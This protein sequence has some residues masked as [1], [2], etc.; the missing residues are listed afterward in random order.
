MSKPKKWE[1][2]GINKKQKICKAGKI[3]LK[4]RLD[5]LT[6]TIDSY[7][8]EQS[9][10]NL[11]QVRI[12]LRRVRYNME[13]FIICFNRKLHLRLYKMV[14]ALQDNSGFVRD[15]DVFEENIKSFKIEE[16]ENNNTSLAATSKVVQTI[17]ESP[18]ENDHITIYLDTTQPGAEI[19]QNYTG[20]VYVHTG[21]NTNQG[22]WRYVIGTWGDNEGQPRLKKL[23]PNL[24]EF[25]IDSPREFYKL[26]DPKERILQMTFVFRSEDGSLQTTQDKA[27]FV[28]DIELSKKETFLAGTIGKVKLTSSVLNKIEERRN[29]LESNLELEL[30][31]FQHSKILKE[32]Y[33]SLN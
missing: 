10:E 30:M 1:I 18:T 27:D 20:T 8:S 6:K 4:S 21:V 15:L 32:F 16:N 3:I 5:H 24:Y 7:F 33:K 11:H 19:L 26:T 14:E 9:V 13:L 22:E 28:N 29:L 31:K 2:D 25:V 23:S 12:A 17:P